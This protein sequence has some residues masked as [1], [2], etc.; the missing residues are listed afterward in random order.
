MNAT[1]CDGSAGRGGEREWREF[2]G[3]GREGAAGTTYLSEREE[4][5]DEELSSASLT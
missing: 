3:R 4:A 1:S 5:N 2:A